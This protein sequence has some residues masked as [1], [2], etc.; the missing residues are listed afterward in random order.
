MAD[1]YA[2]STSTT[3][4]VSVG[5]SRSGNIETAGD[6][7]WFKITLVAG[8]T[9]QFDLRGSPS[10]GGTLADPFLRLRDSAGN[11]ITSDD[12]SGT[13]LDSR[14]TYTATSSGTFYLSVGSST[15]S[16]TGTYTVAA[17]NIAPPDD[18]A[19]ST[20][21]TGAVSVGGSST[22]SIEAAGDTDWFRISLVAGQTYQFD[23]RGSPS[24][25]GT[26]ADP[27][28]RLRD[29]AGNS[30]TSD[31]DSGTG[32]DS[33]ITYTATSS[34]TFYLSVGSSTTSGTG[35][36]TVAATNIA[37]PDDYSS[38]TSTTGAVSVGGSSSGSIEAAGDTDW[39]RISLVAGQSYQFDLRGAPTG[40]GTLADPYLRLR[41]SAGNSLA[42][43]DDNGANLD[44]RITYT[45]TTTG[46]YYLS[47]G[48]STT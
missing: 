41:D 42:F 39:F 10:G 48:S 18:Y 12:D 7:D 38:S 34:G 13:G 37:P 21:T 35:T 30:I 44:S 5:G 19:S 46:T 3:G 6:A 9:Y 36:Y 45:A 20:S 29:S 8:Q 15:T 14:I 43:N 24:G 1:D 25:G 33:R 22:G 16:G 47:A 11:S 4:T 17:T 26:L 23:L 2:A 27:F 32:L 31:D 28:L 40:G